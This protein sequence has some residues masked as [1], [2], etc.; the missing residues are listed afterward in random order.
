MDENYTEYAVQAGK[1]AKNSLRDRIA[2]VLFGRG[3]VEYET[4]YMDG[5][6]EI[7]VIYGKSSRKRRFLCD[8]KQV[9]GYRLGTRDEIFR[10]FGKIDRDFSSGKPG[11]LCCGLKTDTEKGSLIVCFEPGETLA[12]VLESKYRRLKA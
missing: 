10:C 3:L 12:S 2:G 1:T 11:A 6:L 4:I 9:Q 7:S 5:T 8:M